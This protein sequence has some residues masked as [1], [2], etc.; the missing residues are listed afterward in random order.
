MARVKEPIPGVLSGRDEAGAPLRDPQH[1]HAFFL[2]EDHDED[3][4]ID[5]L[6]LYA[7]PGLD[8]AVRRAAE[9]LNKLWINPKDQERIR[10]KDEDNP[11]DEEDEGDSGRR[12][13]RVGLEGFGTPEQFNDSTLLRR[14]RT[15]VSATPYLRPLHLKGDDPFE[16]TCR[17]VRTECERRGWPAPKVQR[18]GCGPDAGRNI[19]VGGRA[20]NVLAFHRFRRRRGLVQPDRTG[21][22]LRLEFTEDVNGLPGPLALGFGCHF[23]LGL[24]H[25]E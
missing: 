1:A 4:F 7:R 15:W 3:G 24:F 5:H 16:E 22:A 14:S 23:G 18:D 2:P 13:W 9:H 6:V 10:R 20:R 12:E 17:M 21:L 11:D 25:A 19:N 8:R